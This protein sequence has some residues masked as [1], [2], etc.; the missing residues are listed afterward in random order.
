MKPCNVNQP[1][2]ES[3]LLLM[4]PDERVNWVNNV[5]TLVYVSCGFDALAR[6]TEQLLSS[7]GGWM[8][9]SATG[10]VLFP[11]SNHVETLCVFKRN[12]GQ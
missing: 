9:E 8:L 6:D 1:Y 2:A 11:G 12:A 4:M 7:N 3:A 10:F 5:D